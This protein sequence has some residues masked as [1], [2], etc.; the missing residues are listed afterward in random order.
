MARYFIF[1]VSGPVSSKVG[2]YPDPDIPSFGPYSQPLI[3]MDP[4]TR[5]EASFSD[6]IAI[7]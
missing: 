7:L 6:K 3:D 2:V 4:V 5:L 1:H